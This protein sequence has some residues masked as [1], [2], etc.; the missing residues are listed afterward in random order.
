[1]NFAKILKIDFQVS[2]STST[3]IVRLQLATTTL[4]SENKRDEITTGNEN[5][6]IGN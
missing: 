3:L 5:I 6:A 4:L 2:S 1:M